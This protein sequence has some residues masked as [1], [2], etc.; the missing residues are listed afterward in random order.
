MRKH[1]LRL[2]F[3]QIGFANGDTVASREES[4]STS[5]FPSAPTSLVTT[6]RPADT[7]FTCPRKGSSWVPKPEVFVTPVPPLTNDQYL[8]QRS[9]Q[10]YKTEYQQDFYYCHRRNTI[11]FRGKFVVKISERKFE[12]S[13][14]SEDKNLIH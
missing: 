14:G 4:T 5:G 9:R 12:S 10:L 6:S 2:M 13:K 3:R 11:F 7:R 1:H 8:V